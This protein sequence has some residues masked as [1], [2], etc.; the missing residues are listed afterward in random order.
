M[1][2]RGFT[3]VIFLF[4]FLKSTSVFSQ[5]FAVNSG[6]I[7]NIVDICFPTDSI[8]YAVTA[9]G[10]VLKTLDQGNNWNT[11][12]T[13]SGSYTSIC[14]LGPDTIF[15]GGNNIYR[16]DDSGNSWNNI[17]SLPYII[18]DLLFFNSK[19]GVY[20]NPYTWT[21][22]HSSGNSTKYEYQVFHTADFGSTW[23]YKF[24]LLDPSSRF[25]LI[26]DSVAYITGDYHT[27]VAHC[28]GP[29]NN[30]GKKTTDK[31]YNWINAPAPGTYYSA[32]YFVNDSLAYFFGDHSTNSALWRMTGS[33]IE[34]VRQNIS[35]LNFVFVNEIDGYLISSANN[36]FKTN[37]E[38]YIWDLDFASV[39]TLNKLLNCHNKQMFAIGMNGTILK[40]EII[41]SLYPDSIYAMYANQTQSNFDTVLVGGVKTKQIVLHNDGSVPLSIHIASSDTFQIS[42]T[43]ITFSPAINYTLA[44]Q[45]DL[46]VYIRFSPGDTLFYTDTLVISTDSLSSIYI[47]LEGFGTDNL[48][49]SL[50]DSMVICRDTINVTGHFTIEN[51]GKLVICPGTVLNF[52][53]NYNFRVLGTLVAEGL[54]NDSIIFKPENN[55]TGWPGLTFFMPTNSDSSIVRFCSLSYA[56]YY[57]ISI[58]YRSKLLIDNC[59][60]YNSR[61]GIYSKYG[62]ITISNNRIFNN[63]SNISG[64]GVKLF[65][66]SSLVINN[67]IFNNIAASG[68]G[69]SMINNPPGSPKIIQNLIFNN[70]GANASGIDLNQGTP[71]LI[72]NT[73]CN[74]LATSPA[75]VGGA[76][77]GAVDSNT[78]VSNNI[79]YNNSGI[80]LYAY[81]PNHL[82]VEYCDIQ[83][84][85]PLGVSNINQNPSFVNPTDSVGVMSQI[86]SYDW[87]I[88]QNSPCINSGN[89]VLNSLIPSFDFGGNSRVYQGRIDIGAY[90]FQPL[91]SINES[92][93]IKW[94]S[95]FPNPFNET[96]NIIVENNQDESVVVLYDM[97]SRK[98]MQ[99][100]FTTSVSLNTQKL[101]KGMYLYEIRS[102]KGNF[103]KG[104]LVKD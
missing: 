90:E 71:S 72:N 17:I 60:I 4:I 45:Q 25:Q 82:L 75:N 19:E 87:S 65:Y 73:I 30:F 95:V 44:A 53:G 84:G 61:G 36:I 12:I 33:N 88:N 59:S 28:T 76:Y 21:C 62:S 31:G 57:A 34:L 8:G 5:W 37:S 97:L 41:E 85:Y 77:F 39:D 83:G 22:T 38:G 68:A 47:P 104:K 29:A 70:T 63:I 24:G 81:Y 11:L 6:T 79:I 91:L 89:M 3:A 102:K 92:G 2:K 94:V 15:V 50:A 46:I 18:P 64:G 93:N 66:D 7:N 52:K 56:N 103:S 58:T 10:D 55:I 48:I 69:I 98:L 32:F 49:G 27:I 26:N 9:N 100:N 78:L 23:Q 101:E 16:S 86:G 20:I 35:A 14:A 1:K 99:L 42:S 74:N 67:E 54:P 43:N 40:K 13:L 51:D 96:V 80:Q